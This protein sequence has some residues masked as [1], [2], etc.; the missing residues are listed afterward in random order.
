MQISKEINVANVYM[1]S[2]MTDRPRKYE[3]SKCTITF[4]IIRYIHRRAKPNRYRG[5]IMCTGED[6]NQTMGEISE[7]FTKGEKLRRIVDNISSFLGEDKRI[8]Q[9]V[10]HIFDHRS[11]GDILMDVDDIITWT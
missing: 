5:H 7:H 3:S 2:H 4:N 9:T 10:R 11:E 1:F 6:V 8:K